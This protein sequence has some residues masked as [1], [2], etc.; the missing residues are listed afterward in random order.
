M[1]VVDCDCLYVEEWG[2]KAAV[3]V[4]VAIDSDSKRMEEE[5]FIF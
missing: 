4:E 2:R 1:R 3:V 5:S